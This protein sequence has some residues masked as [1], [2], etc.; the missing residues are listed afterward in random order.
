MFRPIVAFFV[1]GLVALPALAQ[2]ITMDGVDCQRLTV[3]HVP[4]PDVTYK[5]GVDA[6]GRKVAPADLNGGAAQFTVPDRITFDVAVDLRRYGIPSTSPL[7]EPNLPLG[8]VTVERDG[9]AFYNG[10]PL[11]N[12]EVEALREICKQRGATRR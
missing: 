10:Q 8:K 1:T 12:Q 7:Y 11:Q 5:P 3:T 2:K 9:R 6:Q 4:A